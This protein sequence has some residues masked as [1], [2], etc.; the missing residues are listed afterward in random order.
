MKFTK[1]DFTVIAVFGGVLV[2]VCYAY[3]RKMTRPNP[4]AAA[5]RPA[6]THAVTKSGNPRT[7]PAAT[8]GKPASVPVREY[9]DFAVIPKR[10]LFKSLVKNESPTPKT[11]PRLPPSPGPL[12]VGNTSSSSEDNEVIAVTGVITVGDVQV[13]LVENLTKKETKLARVGTEAFG[14]V[15]ASLDSNGAVLRKDGED[16]YF[17]LGA[18]KPEEKPPAKEEKKAETKKPEEKKSPSSS[19]PPAPSSP[20]FGGRFSN[21]TPQQRLEF[22]RRWEERHR[23]SGR[24]GFGR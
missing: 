18:N 3:Y 9:E 19:S 22:R 11:P 14:Y 10:N 6:K 24:R 5:T 12:P 17:A 1:R 2:V 21:L 8:A 15:V 13:A 23:R 16:H 7:D 20:S 4:A